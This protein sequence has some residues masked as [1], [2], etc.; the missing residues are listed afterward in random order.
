MKKLKK[1]SLLNRIWG[2]FIETKSGDCM[3]CGRPEFL[4][5]IEDEVCGRAQYYVQYAVGDPDKLLQDIVDGPHLSD[6]KGDESGGHL[7]AEARAFLRKKLH[8]T[9]AARA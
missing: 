9:G 5:C 4:D 6:L 3:V 7:L 1:M 8:A 2:F